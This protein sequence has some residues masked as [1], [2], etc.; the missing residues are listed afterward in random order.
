MLLGS[1]AGFIAHFACSALAAGAAIGAAWFPGLCMFAPKMCR[2][3]IA[4]Q[5]AAG[6]TIIIGSLLLSHRKM[7]EDPQVL[8]EMT[9][10]VNRACGQVVL[11]KEAS[12]ASLQTRLGQLVVVLVA[13]L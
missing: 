12:I 5:V 4:Y 11:L 7:S 1:C 6:H 2:P 13:L 10:A 9:A 3:R 8:L